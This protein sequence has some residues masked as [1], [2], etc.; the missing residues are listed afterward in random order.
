MKMPF[1]AIPGLA[2]CDVLLHPF[3]W[4]YTRAVNLDFKVKVWATSPTGST[5]FPNDSTDLNNVSLFDLEATAK[6][7]TVNASD[8]LTIDYVLNVDVNT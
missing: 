6:H 7:V 2:R 3:I 1:T 8:A 4:I 5:N